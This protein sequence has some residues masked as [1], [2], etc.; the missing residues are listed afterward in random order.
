MPRIPNWQVIDTLRK[1]LLSGRYDSLSLLPSER[2]LAAELQVGRGVIRTALKVLQ[3]ENIIQL[4]PQRGI[5]LNPDA[6]PRRLKRFLVRMPGVFSANSHELFAVLSGICLA[7]AERHAEALVSSANMALSASEVIERYHNNDIQGLI[8][9]ELLED[10][11]S[12]KLFDAAGV[13]RVVANM[14][15]ASL[16]VHTC[17]DF[18]R[19]GAL[20]AETLLRAGHRRI[21]WVGGKLDRFAVQETLRGFEETLKQA[22]VVLPESWRLATMGSDDQKFYAD[23]RRVLTASES[24]TAFFATRDYRAEMIYQVAR[25]L[26]L[27]IPAEI[28]VLGYDNVSWPGAAYAQ[29]STMKQ[30][31]REMGYGAVELL[32]EWYCQ[33]KTPESK[34][35]APELLLRNSIQKF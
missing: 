28:S 24:P 6:S 30:A 5:R 12:Q 9:V 34:V 35:Y 33:N 15:D 18:Y 21:G 8:Y 29:L 31:A 19:T 4:I 22:G 3:D 2:Q 14:E 16:L 7:G 23:L 11:E 32:E 1:L 20:A 10:H 27:T 13:P 17:M 26:K 25:E